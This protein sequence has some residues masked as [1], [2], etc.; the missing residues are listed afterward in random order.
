[1]ARTRPRQ[2][3]RRE[4]GTFFLVPHDVHDSDNYLDCSGNGIKLVN[5][6]ARQ[7][8]GKNNGDLCASWSY[9]LKRGWKSPDT[10]DR[11]TQEALHYGLIERTRQGGMRMCNLYALTWF[12]IDDCDGKLDRPATLLPPGT[13]KKS[14][15]PFV[16]PR[17]NKSLSTDSV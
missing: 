15:G 9:M 8:N 16:R 10:L 4:K 17:R 2:T 12:A 5:T 6:L 1:M 14:A 13:W 7:Y 3:G 11:A